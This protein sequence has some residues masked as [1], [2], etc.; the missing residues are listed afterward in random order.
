MRRQVGTFANVITQAVKKVRATLQT[1]GILIA[2]WAVLALVG[3]VAG[4]LPVQEAPPRLASA[5]SAPSG[6]DGGLAGPD[7]DAGLASVDAGVHPQ[8]GDSAV[9][10]PVDAG[11][12][13]ASRPTSPRWIVCEG[14]AEPSFAL[15]S[16]FGAARPEL[17]IGCGDRWEVVVL[18]ASGPARVAT[19]TSPAAP[20]GQRARTGPAASGD[21]DGD[22][23][24]DLVLPLA[25]ETEQGAARGGGLFWI[26]KDE[27]GGIREPI[28]LAWVATSSA[29]V[30]PLDGQGGAEVVAMHRANALAQ[31]PS[32]AWVFGGGAAPTRRATVPAG[33]AGSMVEVGDLDRDGHLDV[34]TL[35]RDRIGLAF[36][37]GDGGFPRTHSFTFEGAREIALGDIDGDGGVDLVVLGTELRWIP[38]GP[39]ATM[40]PRLVVNAPAGLRGV[41]V[42]D[43]DGDGKRDLVAWHHPRLI[44]LR[45]QGDETFE[46]EPL[47]T[48][49]G[50]VFGPRRHL[51]LDADGDGRRDDLALLGTS[52][53]GSPVELLLAFDVFDGGDLSPAP[54]AG[55]LP[56]APL[57][58]G[59]ALPSGS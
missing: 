54:Q 41:S 17:V 5:E 20:S 45:Q 24:P 6:P 21:V 57:M 19:F 51:L 33:L 27:F 44:V 47:V 8:I 58:L 2:L 11:A 15:V 59:G 26:P 13:A 48:L 31:L 50:D 7:E 43:V 56:D 39:L 25:F 46:E 42:E 29:R 35:G 22:G 4:V 1:L 37:D 10:V 23:H 12:V 30:A 3:F 40:E 49:T 32:E 36:G 55:I 16:L 53:E 38:A 9:S 34:I 52:G 28:A 14:T 18:T